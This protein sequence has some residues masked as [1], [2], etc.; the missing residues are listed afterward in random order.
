MARVGEDVADRALLD[1]LAAVHH[2]D[3]V[4]HASHRAEVVADV[5]NRGV[6]PLAERPDEVEDRRLHRDVQ[7][8]RGLV[9]DEQRGRRDEGHRDD[10][11]LLLAPRELVRIAA[12]DAG[13]VGQVDLLQHAAGALAGGA[14][15][16]PL[17]EHRDFHELAADGH[18]GIQARHRILVDHRDSPT[19]EPADL[20][21]VHRG[22]VLALE[23][24]PAARDPPGPPEEAHDAE[25]DRRLAAAGLPHQPEGLSLAEREAQPRDDRDLAGPGEVGDPDVLELEERRPGRE[26]G[27]RPPARRRLGAPGRGGLPRLSHAARFPG[28]RPRGD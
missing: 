21:L 5:E 4:A 13:R 9:H 1:Q 15:P 6:V 2:P 22:Q 10:D 19:A 26:R 20:D 8:R 18:H 11:P 27:P 12:E 25:G 24:D 14:R 17:V 28:G 3:P 16:D 7:P 23:E